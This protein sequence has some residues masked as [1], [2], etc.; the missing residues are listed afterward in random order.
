M[1]QRQAVYEAMRAMDTNSL[2]LPLNI[3][4]VTWEYPVDPISSMSDFY[5]RTFGYSASYDK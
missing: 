1:A 3:Y 5:D 2:F 4:D